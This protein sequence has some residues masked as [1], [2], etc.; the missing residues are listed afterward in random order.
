MVFGYLKNTVVFSV[1]CAGIISAG[2]VGFFAACDD[3]NNPFSNSLGA[4]VDIE[5][6]TI[7]VTSPISGYLLQGVSRFEGK[8]KAY[9][10]LRTVEIKIHDFDETKDPILDWTETGVQLSRDKDGEGYHHWYYDLDTKNFFGPAISLPDGFVKV[11][12]RA[13]DK[14][15]SAD[16]VELV[17]IVKN[18]PSTIKLTAPSD[19]ELMAGTLPM[20]LTDGELFGQII[21]RRGIKPGYP[22]IKIWP[23]DMLEPAGDDPNWGW[24]QL[25]LSGIDDLEVGTGYYA[26]RTQMPVVRVAEFKLRLSQFTINKDTRHIVYDRSGEGGSFKPLPLKVYNFRILTSDTF[27][28]QDANEDPEVYLFPRDR[29]PAIDDDDDQ[30]LIGYYPEDTDALF[31]DLFNKGPYYSMNVDEEGIV[32]E[33]ELDNDDKTVTELTTFPN[34]YMT[35]STAMKTFKDGQDIFRLRIRAAHLSETISRATLTWRHPGSNRSGELPWDNTIAGSLGYVDPV[36]PAAGHRGAWKDSSNTVAG[37]NFVFTGIGNKEYTYKDGGGNEITGSVFT[38]SSDPY[39]LTVMVYSESGT[40]SMPAEYTVYMDGSSPTVAIRSIMGAYDVPKGN[41]RADTLLGDT[42]SGG[43]INE[44]EYVVNGNIRVLVE[45]PVAGMGFKTV[46]WIVEEDILSDP[47]NP[48]SP[49]AYLTAADTTLQKLRTYFDQP[50]AA[51]F[52]FYD[53]IAEGKPQAG[54]AGIV[55]EGNDNLLASRP[56]YLNLNTVK[57]SVANN[58]WNK[59]NLWLYIIV[60][61]SVQNLGFTLQKLYVDDDT[62]IPKLTVP[63]FTTDIKT[64]SDLLYKDNPS[65]RNM[66]GRGEGIDLTVTD[67]DGVS[68]PSGVTVVLTDLNV[69]PSRSVS[70]PIGRNVMTS[71]PVTYPS[72]PD[73]SRAWNGSLSAP[74]MAEA[75]RGQ[76]ATYL[77]DG[78]YSVAITVQDNLAVKVAID[79]TRPG[80]QPTSRSAV[81]ATQ[82]FYFAVRSQEPVVRIVTPE[83]GSTQNKTPA[84]ISGTVRSPFILTSLNITFTPDVITP[85]IAV[86]SRTLPLVIPANPSRGDD[87]MYTYN[88]SHAAVNF[89]P[90]LPNDG[91]FP[92]GERRIRVDVVDGMGYDHSNEVRVSVD[93]D[94]PEIK[95]MTFNFDRGAQMVTVGNVQVPRYIVNGKVPFTINAFDQGGIRNNEVRNA[96]GDVTTPATLVNVCWW[97]QTS[98]TAPAWAGGT[99]ATPAFPAAPNGYGGRFG[100]NAATTAEGSDYAV[101]LDTRML[102]DKTTYYLF[103]IAEDKA[104]NIP[105]SAQ[106]LREFYVDQSTDIPELDR[107]LLE[108]FN[109]LI[110]TTTT[111]LVFKGSVSDDDGFDSNQFTRAGTNTDTN[112]AYVQIRFPQNNSI[113]ITEPAFGDITWGAWLTISNTATVT[114]ALKAGSGGNDIEFTYIPPSGTAYPNTHLAGNGP[115]FYQIRVTDEA[116]AG[117]GSDGKNPV[118][119]TATGAGTPVPANPTNPNVPVQ[120][121]I[122]PANDEYYTFGIKNSPPVVYFRT[123]DPDPNHNNP[124]GSPARPA[125]RTASEMIT[126]LGGG[127]VNDIYLDAASLTITYTSNAVSGPAAPVTLKY[128]RTPATGN[129]YYWIIDSTVANNNVSGYLTGLFES[130]GNGMH[131][132]TIYAADTVGGFTEAE[133]SFYKDDKPPVISASL[134]RVIKG[135]PNEAI[136]VNGTF[137]DDISNIGPIDGSTGPAY[138]YRFFT[139]LASRGAYTRVNLPTTPART[140]NWTQT[141]PLSLLDGECYLELQVADALGNITPETNPAVGTNLFTFVLDRAEPLV[142]PVDLMMIKVGNYTST[143]ASTSSGDYNAN[144]TRYLESVNNYNPAGV[145]LQVGSTVNVDGA[146]RLVLWMGSTGTGD[147]TRYRIKVSTGLTG[148]AATTVYPANGGAAITNQAITLKLSESARVFSAGAPTAGDTTETFILRGL[149]YERN[150]TELA[151]NVNPLLFELKNIDTWNGTGIYGTGQLTLMPASAN[152]RATHSSQQTDTNSLYTKSASDLVHLYAWELK[153][154]RGN[155][156]ALLAQS[157][158][159]GE[160]RSIVVEAKDVAQ[161]KSDKDN[162]R[163]YLDNAKPKVTFLNANNGTAFETLNLQGLIEDDTF[164]Q[165][166][167]FTLAKYVMPAAPGTYNYETQGYWRYYTGTAWTEP[168]IAADINH[169]SWVELLSAGTTG[170]SLP[171]SLTNE[172]LASNTYYRN[173]PLDAEGRYRIDLY[174]TDT[175]LSAVSADKGN[176]G[177]QSLEFYV[178]KGGPAINWVTAAKDFYNSADLT[179]NLTA[180]DINSIQT[181][182]AVVRP[183]GSSSG[184]TSVTVSPATPTPTVTVTAATT[185][186]AQSAFTVTIPSTAVS[187]GSRYTLSLTVTDRAGKSAASNNT[188]SF[189]VDNA[190][191]AITVT[192]SATNAIVGRV[193]FQGTFTKA[194]GSSP[195]ARVAFVLGGAAPTTAADTRWISS[196]GVQKNEGVDM[197]DIDTGLAAVKM[198]LFDTDNL[199]SSY[200]TGA[201]DQTLPAGLAFDG[202]PLPSGAKGNTLPIH[203]LAVD[204]AGNVQITTLTYYVYPEGNIPRVTAINNPDPIAIEMDRRMNGR[205]RISGAATDNVRV[206]YVWF[207]V[208]DMEP[209]TNY[210]KPITLT[211]VPVW[212]ETTWEQPNPVTYQTA[213]SIKRYD[214]AAASDGWYMANGGGSRSVAWWAYINGNGE[215]DPSGLNTERKI[216][217]EV[218]AEDTKLGADGVTWQSGRGTGLISRIPAATP[219]AEIPT[220]TKTVL[221]SVVRGA[222][223]FGDEWAKSGASGN[224]TVNEANGWGEVSTTSLRK[225]AAY[226]ITVQ[227]ELGVGAINWNQGATTVN[228][229]NGPASLSGISVRAIPKSPITAATINVPAATPVNLRTYLIWKPGTSVP[230]VSLDG[231]GALIARDN[232]QYTKFTAA[233]GT[234]I[235]LNGAILLPMTAEGVFE[236]MV[237]ADLDID[238]LGDN[239][240][241]RADWYLLRLSASEVSKAVPLTTTYDARIPIDNMKPVGMYTH[242]TNVVGSAPSFGGEAADPDGVVKGLSKVVMWFSRVTGGSDQSIIWDELAG[243]GTF[244][245]DTTTPTADIANIGNKPSTVSLPNTYTAGTLPTTTPLFRNRSSIV[246]DRHDPSGRQPH[247]GHQHRMGFAPGGMGTNWYVILDSTQMTSGRTTA[248]FLVYDKAGNATYY[249]QKLMILNNIPRI[250]KITLGTDIRGDLGLQDAG[251]LGVS[252]QNRSIS[253]VGTTYTGASNGKS[254][255]Q[256]IRERFTGAA[257]KILQDSVDGLAGDAL[258]TAVGIRTVTVNTTTIGNYNVVYDE[259]FNVRNNLL[260]IGVDISQAMTTKTRHYRMEYVTTGTRRVGAAFYNNITAGRVY[261]IDV[262]GTDFPWALFGAVGDAAN[263]KRGFVFLATESSANVTGLSGTYGNVA[264]WELTTATTGNQS[265]N[266]VLYPST[267]ASTGNNPTSATGDNGKRAEFVYGTSAFTA[268]IPDYTPIVDTDGRP[269][270]FLQTGA[271]SPWNTH[272]LFVV[273]VFDAEPRVNGTV[274]DPNPTPTPDDQLFGDF[275]LLAIQVN[276]SDKTRSFAQLYDLNPKSEEEEAMA[277]AIDPQYMGENRF[278]GGLW[279]TTNENQAIVKSGHV[280]PRTTTSLTGRDMGGAASATQAYVYRPVVTDSAYFNVD[281]VSG[282]VILRGY[283]ED[284]QRIGRVDLSLGGTTV[285]ILEYNNTGSVGSLLRAATNPNTQKTTAGD[286]VKFVET[287]DLD[288]HRVE[289][290]YLWNTQTVP[291]TIVGDVT[292]IAR[293]YTYTSALASTDR[294]RDAATTTTFDYY[295]PDFPTYNT[296]ATNFRRYNQIGMNLRPYITGIIRNKATYSYQ[297]ERSMQGRYML[298]REEQFVLAGFNLGGATGTANLPTLALPNMNATVVTATNGTTNGVLTAAGQTAF[299]LPNRNEYNYRIFSVPNTENARTGTGIVGYTVNG[300]A[301]VNARTIPVRNVNRAIQPWNTERSPGIAGSDL[302]DDFTAVHIWQSN[303]TTATGNTANNGYFR[304]T[305]DNW[306]IMN[307]AMSVV[308]GTGILHASHN[309]NG[310]GGNEGSLMVSTNNAATL[311]KI[312]TFIDPIIC[313]DIYYSPGTSN[314]GAARWAVTSIIGQAGNYTA[315]GNLGGV[316]LHGPGGADVN[317]DNLQIRTSVETGYGG[318]YGESTWYNAGNNNTDR[319]TDQF[320]NPHIITSY[321]NSTNGNTEYIHVSYYDR[322]DGSIKYKFNQRSS[323]GVVGANT[324][325]RSWTNLDGGYDA[326]DQTALTASAPF[327]QV[328]ANYRIVNYNTRPAAAANRINAGEHNAIAVTSGGFPVIAYYDATNQKLKLAVSGAVNPVHANNWVIVDVLVGTD[329]DDPLASPYKFGTGQYVS[330]AIDNGRAGPAGSDVLANRIHIAA[331]NTNGNLVYIRGLIRPPTSATTDVYSATANAAGTFTPDIVQIVDNVGTVGRWCKI[332]LDQYGRPWIAYQDDGKIGSTQGAKIAYRGT[333]TKELKDDNG[334]SIAG[335]ETMHVPVQNFRVEN[336]SISGRE[337]GRLGLECFP[338]RNTAATG[339]QFWDAAVSYFTTYPQTRY[340]IAYYVR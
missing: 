227:H 39:M 193:E 20:I 126:A 180:N 177:T 56:Y 94:P 79:G 274:I 170:K 87:G 3:P 332:S 160:R 281:T 18:K 61:D 291:N 299:A 324:A 107:S 168:N 195:V 55:R 219:A 185:S 267:N 271:T 130:G 313:S 188:I 121:K 318:Y 310:S 49:S 326:E 63:R 30:E 113:T 253:L 78:F 236:W 75:L 298:A 89:A 33:I 95:L 47:L 51:N 128:N 190:K 325:P 215:L 269:L 82:T 290:A 264:G 137:Y 183:Y 52:K 301:A 186:N 306:P 251:N 327:P 283:V 32:P 245:P 262:P 73:S 217:I 338:T 200:Y 109:V 296:N 333:F 85:T 45:R 123:S 246:I 135:D 153:I 164:V 6:P 241:T 252:T 150:L 169:A 308:P 23:E 309:E 93:N 158:I 142:S 223:R 17:Y 229:F 244:D 34:I 4:K 211:S 155:L 157:A 11:Q 179:F 129:D 189:L 41:D 133:W 50:T 254:A 19:D 315:W 98:A 92:S 234:T 96:A 263:Y 136:T 184:G 275:A 31:P 323:P 270:P 167:K 139:S 101:V 232:V 74:I 334:T 330:I 103:A 316:Y 102:N 44:Y 314:L 206:K 2:V 178:D 114:T 279:A 295:N 322:K 65:R 72:V 231:G 336:P 152:D 243:T 83:E 282:E 192:P 5:P 86:P 25:F 255:L 297:D 287:I 247:H 161:R 118:P 159:N 60:E 212:N 181:T 84:P 119:V 27:F 285:T 26:D 329:R 335:W 266:Q 268:G 122:F 228:L 149:V 9:R 97:V 272:S 174:F 62:D 235:T 115:K 225:Q 35:E 304:S 239:W 134:A 276:N 201:L 286:R 13:R 207:R 294:T 194:T 221:A 319:I 238:Q 99:A 250:T 29:N 265:V 203:F 339:T 14:N 7:T 22:R 214:E 278:R 173:N 191:P 125:F 12:F 28:N 331:M 46:K 321:N 175:S 143:T 64:A 140:V 292:V 148:T 112:T 163:F 307:P 10:E 258:D 311:T 302:W 68:L 36:N 213:Q 117:S 67:D 284:D 205:I 259:R 280:E 220:N 91:K 218:I 132:I 320:L 156:A 312:I 165:S 21:D 257:E 337:N 199:P 289:W 80:D 171:W 8:A 116:A 1:I 166:L 293:A 54:M 196:G 90:D 277:D 233:T 120:R 53:D 76:G 124:I 273:R 106:L 305:G 208:L 230:T 146:D 261:M 340:R 172:T 77:L 105:S 43:R 110:N 210:E 104:G 300:S 111:D 303:D 204:E 57:N 187:S 222:P 24:A 131:T 58:G 71:G 42:L 16:T 249:S 248:H 81:P 224:D 100:I 328:T 198:V 59:Q 176:P 141:I 197:M 256:T 237:I 48:T 40:P 242:T 288:R 145:G 240:S 15:L 37:K 69:T 226:A 162:W 209:G 108:P 66:L 216:K 38:T 147:A 151:A 260:T 70:I 138:R 144:L 127:R 317:A 202:A 182:T 88:W 154:T